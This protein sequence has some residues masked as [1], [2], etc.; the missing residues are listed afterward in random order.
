MTI[1]PIES[2]SWPGKGFG[3]LPGNKV[4]GRGKARDLWAAM[5]DRRLSSALRRA[6]ILSAAGRALADQGFLPVAMEQVAREA[7]VS[8][9]LI[10]AYF[11]KPAAL[12]GA[13]LEGAL[14]AL[15]AQLG[16]I[17]AKSFEA[18]A[19]AAALIYF[20]EVAEHGARLHILLTDVFLDGARSGEATALR[21][22]LWLKLLRASRAYVDL[23][24][25][26]R[27]AAMAMLMAI[28]EELGRLAHRGEITHERARTLCRQ[29]VISSLRGLKGARR[30]AA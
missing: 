27:V 21:D 17:R 14:D 4:D 30:A 18:E 11:P 28:P 8:K 23:P 9:A 13:L 2:I 1:T 24:P 10:Y 3:G 19:A 26:E 12:Y 20:D 22:V 6:E 16:A 7:G 5:P 15:A 25:E 29:I